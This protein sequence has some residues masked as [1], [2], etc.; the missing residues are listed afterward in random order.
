MTYYRPIV[1]ETGLALAGGWAT[2]NQ[3]EIITRGQ[4]REIVA[5]DAVPDDVRARLTSPRKPI[6]GVEIQKP[7]VMGILNVTP[8][9]FSDGGDFVSVDAAFAQAQ[10]MQ[11]NGAAIIDVGGESTRPGAQEVPVAEEIARVAP[12]IARIAAQS[13]VVVSLDTRKASVLDAVPTPVLLND[14]TALRFDPQMAQAVAARHAPVCLMHSIA[15]PETMQAQAHY[16]DVLLDVYDH[17]ETQVAFACGEGILRENIIIDPGVGFGKTLEH[18]LAL[19][20]GLSL[21]HGLGCPI[22]LGASRKRFIGTLGQAPEA[23]DRL[24]GSVAVALEGV[25][26]G[27]QILRVHDTY[28]TKQAIDLQM[29][30]G[31]AGKDGT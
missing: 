24:G 1:S 30:I 10:Q 27:V 2:F 5:A 11:A 15:T 23:K 14:V 8:D 13:D 19:I 31:K 18:N 22:L 6:M 25:R 26:Q 3:V 28:A 29:A 20:R 12:V 17:L 21:F 9:S 4:G 7:A 16:D